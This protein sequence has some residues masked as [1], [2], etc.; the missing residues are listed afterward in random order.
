MGCNQGQK[1]EG[2]KPRIVFVIGGPGCGKGTQ[3]KRIVQN[4]NYVSFSNV[5]NLFLIVS[6]LSSALP[7]FLPSNLLVISSLLTSI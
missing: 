4:F 6:S 2:D 5:V 1:V 3:C 7:S